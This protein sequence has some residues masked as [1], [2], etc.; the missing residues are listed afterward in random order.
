MT[1]LK[2]F[3]EIMS[4]YFKKSCN[5]LNTIF[6]DQ[7]QLQNDEIEAGA[8]VIKEMAENVFPAYQFEKTVSP[9][10]ASHNHLH[11]QELS[12]FFVNQIIP[13]IS[14]KANKEG[15]IPAPKWMN[16]DFLVVLFCSFMLHDIGMQLFAREISS[17]ELW[18]H[19]PN[20]RVREA[21]DKKSLEFIEY[22]LKG[23]YWDKAQ[24]KSQRNKP[25]MDNWCGYWKERS[26]DYPQP[27]KDFMLLV[28]P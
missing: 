5:K 1:D 24:A 2:S 21:H 10:F 23:D 19:I 12:S 16:V 7:N 14:I 8:I 11:A 15:E 25:K 3:K 4:A 9:I 20:Q 28:L 13:A 18:K 17:Y 26:S 6:K 22:L 27:T